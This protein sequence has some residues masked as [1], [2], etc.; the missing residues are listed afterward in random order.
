MQ[1]QQPFDGL[2]FFVDLAHHLNNT[3]EIVLK[4]V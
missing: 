1:V 3:P 2:V 4:H